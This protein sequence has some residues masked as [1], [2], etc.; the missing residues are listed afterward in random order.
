MLKFKGIGYT[1]RFS[2][3]FNIDSK[4]EFGES[5]LINEYLSKHLDEALEGT[6]EAQRIVSIILKI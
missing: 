3:C 6:M 1:R 4:G 5:V 2:E